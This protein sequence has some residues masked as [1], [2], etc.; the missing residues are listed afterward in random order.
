MDTKELGIRK[1]KTHSL[2]FPWLNGGFQSA[3]TISPKEFP[4]DKKIYAIQ[5]D[6]N[7]KI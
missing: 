4:A 3:N 6:T 1:T 5:N 7:K 2:S